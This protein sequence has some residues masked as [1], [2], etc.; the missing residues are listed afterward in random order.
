MALLRAAPSVTLLMIGYY[1]A[2]LDRPLDTG[3]LIEFV[4]ALAVVGAVVAWQVRTILASDVPRL[5]EI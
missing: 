4:L 3:T 2:P 1:L 5:R